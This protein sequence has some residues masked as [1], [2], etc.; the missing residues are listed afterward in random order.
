MSSMMMSSI[1][2]TLLK[3]GNH[4]LEPSLLLVAVFGGKSLLLHASRLE[5]P[6]LLLVVVVFGEKSL[7]LHATAVVEVCYFWTIY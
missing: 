4:N 7:V 5:P 3:D 1:R 6:S 2:P